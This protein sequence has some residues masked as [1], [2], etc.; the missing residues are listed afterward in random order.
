MTLT[1]DIGNGNI[2]SFAL[3]A[4]FAFVPSLANQFVYAVPKTSKFFQRLFLFPKL[5]LSEKNELLFSYNNKDQSNSS[6]NAF[7]LSYYKKSREMK[8]K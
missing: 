1:S 3:F 4:S 8:S 5:F 7:S 2:G 6:N